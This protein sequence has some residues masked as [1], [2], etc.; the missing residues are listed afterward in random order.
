[1]RLPRTFEALKSH[2]YRLLWLGAVGS[3][4]G[5]QMRQI[6]NGWLAFELTGSAAVLA[7]VTLGQAL[8][9]FF[10][11]MFGGVIADRVKKR[12]LLLF[13][14]SCI[15]LDSLSMAILVSTGLIEVWMIAV[16]AAVHGSV[17]SFNQPSRQAYMVELVEPNQM[18]NAIA[19]YNSGQ[20]CVRILGPSIAGALIT[21]PFIGLTYVFYVITAFYLIPVALLFMI[22][23]RPEGAPRRRRALLTDFRNGISYIK[24]HEVLKVLIIA[25]LIPPLLGNHYQQFL[26]VFASDKVLNVG[27]SGLG[28]MATATGIGAFLG[29]MCVASF[30]NMRRRGLVQLTTGALFGITLILFSQAPAFPFAIATLVIVGFMASAYQTLNSTLAVAASDPAY[31][32]RVAS[33]Q[34]MNNSMSSFAVLPFGYSVDKFGAP[35]VVLCSGIAI[36]LFWTFVGLFVPAYRRIELPQ[37]REAEEAEAAG[38]GPAPERAS[39]PS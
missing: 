33:V 21:L 23:P 11:A 35:T 12:R 15:V 8:P 20:T 36:T 16:L 17:L 3:L 22:K 14:Q 9:G 18:T 37:D 2:D 31:Y 34:Q 28:L 30:G 10:L 4:T 19:L 38:S 29:S 24:N 6:A 7:M 1:M 32:G 26:P 25:G 39:T 5:A 13:T 27:A